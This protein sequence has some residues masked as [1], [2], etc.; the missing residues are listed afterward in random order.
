MLR[1]P[2]CDTIKWRNDIDKRNPPQEI[3]EKGTR[4]R[5]PSRQTTALMPDSPAPA[6][7]PGPVCVFGHSGVC[8]M[9]VVETRIYWR[10]LVLCPLF[11]FQGSG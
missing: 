3:S 2:I 4:I 6:A 1:F 11:R 5:A 7:L 9:R 10:R 8:W